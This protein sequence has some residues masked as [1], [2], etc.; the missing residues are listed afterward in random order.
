MACHATGGT[1]MTR[2]DIDTVTVSPCRPYSRER[3]NK[4]VTTEV[5]GSGKSKING[6][7]DIKEKK[8]I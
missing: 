4:Y 5:L 1:K 2:W 6:A 8:N 7:S 3:K